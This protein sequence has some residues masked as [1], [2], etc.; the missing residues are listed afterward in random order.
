MKVLALCSYPIQAAATRYRLEQFVNPLAERDIELSIRPFLDSK[1]FELMYQREAWLPISTGLLRA[2]LRRL[3]DL[4]GTLR[5]NVVLIQRESMIFGPP[6]IEWFIARVC[7]IP[8][9]LDLDDATYVPYSS[10]TYGRLGRA[11]KWVGKTDTLIHLSRMVTC[12]NRAIAQYVSSRGATT[13]IIPTVV[14]TEIFCP[15]EHDDSTPVLGWIGT[16]STYPYLESIFP[17]LQEL[18]KKHEFR[19][20]IVGAG[21]DAI[22]LAGVE[23]ENLKWELEREVKDFQSLD[24][25]L[26]PIDEGM[27]AAQ[28]AAGKSGFKAIQYMAVGIPYVATPVGAVVEIGEEGKTHFCARSPQEWLDALD[29]LLLDSGRR[30]QMGIEGRQHVTKHYGL[31]AQT[32][33]LAQ[34]LH[35]VAERR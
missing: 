1:L 25:G 35:E 32:E 11:L 9:I 3:R 12:G 19:L 5:A 22:S 17:V 27:Y 14:D 13:R 30:R 31:P 34:A 4:L 8:I 26:Y 16:H 20:K 15:A 7:K 6:V 23:I 24:I 21:K 10:P 18:A 33:A 29:S 2:S 28:W